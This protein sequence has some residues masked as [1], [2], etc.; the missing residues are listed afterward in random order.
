MQLFCLKEIQDLKLIEFKEN[1]QD[2]EFDLMTKIYIDY[3]DKKKL[4]LD[5]YQDGRLPIHLAA[6]NYRTKVL[7]FLIKEMKGSKDIILNII[8]IDEEKHKE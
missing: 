5:P 4:L 7:K 2:G 6:A 8:S 1:V 3:D